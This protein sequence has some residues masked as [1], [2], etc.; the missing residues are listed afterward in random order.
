MDQRG[1]SYDKYSMEAP[2]GKTGV[3]FGLVRSRKGSRIKVIDH[4]L[5]GK[6]ISCPYCIGSEKKGR[7]I[8]DIDRETPYNHWY[9]FIDAS[10]EEFELYYTDQLT[11]LANSVAITDQTIRVKRLIIDKVDENAWV[12]L[13]KKTPTTL[14]Y[15]VAYE[16]GIKDEKYLGDIQSVELTP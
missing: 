13:R 3:A 14:E 5:S 15:V 6:E 12:Y 16:D 2:T 10:E 4:N 8:V 1:S 11:T 7:F 9:N